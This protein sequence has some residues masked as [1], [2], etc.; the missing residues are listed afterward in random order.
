MKD[1]RSICEDAGYSFVRTD[2]KNVY[3]KLDGFEFKQSK[4]NFPPKKLN[5]KNCNTPEAWVVYL[6]HNKHNGL[7]GYDRFEWTGDVANT[8]LFY[9]EVH[10]YFEQIINGHLR[11]SGCKFCSGNQKLN[12]ADVLERCVVAR[13]EVY[14]YSDFK[15]IPEGN[16][17]TIKCKT[18][19]EFT[20][21]LYSHLKGVDCMECS[22]LKPS[23]TLLS[24]SEFEFK[25]NTRHNYKYDYSKAEYINAHTPVTIICSVHGDFEQ[26]P[27]YHLQGNGCQSCGSELVGFGRKKYKNI[28]P[29][30]SY[31][32]LL[33]ITSPTER[34][35]KIG[36]SKDVY[37]RVNKLRCEVDYDFKVIGTFFSPDAGVV[38]D[39]ETLLHKE[40]AE[41]KY[42]PL[43]KFAGQT[44]C[45]ML[46]SVEEVVKLIKMIL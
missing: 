17:I 44:E 36:I 32:Y 22:L 31:V 25:A 13:G 39:T 10:G 18:H 12:E 19:G 42:A 21:N 35:Y 4:Y 20:T 41:Y 23:A 3:F 15:Y 11:G 37:V 5:I 26:V 33:E 9:C 28:C 8:S 1:W 34:F 45:F 40:F 24:Q 30:G 16:K 2:S 14:D 46:P 29:D 7:Y 27:Y 38:F 43:N 6:M